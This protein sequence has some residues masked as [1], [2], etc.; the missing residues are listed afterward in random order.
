[1]LT[2]LAVTH[3][4]R[5]SITRASDTVESAQFMSEH[6]YGIFRAD[7]GDKWRYFCKGKEITVSNPVR[8]YRNTLDG[9]YDYA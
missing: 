4:G 8:V 2:E 3:N 9:G 5:E 7:A 6:N 1:M